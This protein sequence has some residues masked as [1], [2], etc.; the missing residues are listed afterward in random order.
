MLKQLE[1]IAR[2]F[3]HIGIDRHKSCA[4]RGS[5]PSVQGSGFAKVTA[6]L[7]HTYARVSSLKV[8][9]HIEA[10]IGTPVINENDLVAVT[11]LGTRETLS[12]VATRSSVAI[13]SSIT[14]HP[15]AGISIKLRRACKGLC[16][17]TQEHWRLTAHF[18]DVQGRCFTL[19]GV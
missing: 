4:T 6:K 7:N 5:K 11:V 9:A 15:D 2:I 8:G 10:A 13:R 16:G 1:H 17:N 18:S 3:L 19:A 14:N 12:C